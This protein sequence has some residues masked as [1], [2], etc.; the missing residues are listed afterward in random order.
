MV[1]RSSEMPDQGGRFT[2]PNATRTPNGDVYLVIRDVPDRRLYR[3][4]NAADAWSRVAIFV[5]QPD[6]VVY[7]DDVVPD[8][9]GNLHIAWEWGFSES[10]LRHLGSYAR[11]EPATGKFFDAAGT[12]LATPIGTS[13]TAVYQ[14]S[15]PASR[16]PT[17]ATRPIH[18]GSSRPSW[19]STRPRAPRWRPTACG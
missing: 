19:P 10:G 6:F 16:R 2:Y 13:G 9:A 1:D 7:P 15:C 8:A 17:R 14:P 3:W 12:V 11:Y 4:D 5:S 18:P